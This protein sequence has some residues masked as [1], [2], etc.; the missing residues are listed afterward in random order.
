MSLLTPSFGMIFWMIIAFIVVLLILRSFAWKPI[1]NAL[2]E[3]EYNI[4]EALRS[5]DNAKKEMKKLKA[6]NE[7]IIAEGQ[8]EKN[9]IL[10]EARETREKM[11]NDAKDEA[12]RE[13]EKIIENAKISIAEEKA[14]VLAELRNKVVELSVDIAEKIIKDHLDNDKAQK[15]LIDDLL[16]DVKFN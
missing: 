16:N 2:R 13:A 9:E 10:K 7:K 15:E 3:R 1:L 12:R 4:K 8:K 6:D 11:I 5:A 14:A